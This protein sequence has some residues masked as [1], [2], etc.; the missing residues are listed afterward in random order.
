MGS[1]PGSGKGVRRGR[2]R[3]RGLGHT[4]LG[5]SGCRPQGQEARGTEQAIPT[6]RRGTRGDLFCGAPPNLPLNNVLRRPP[7][8]HA[9]A[10]QPQTG[11]S[12][13]AL[14]PRLAAVT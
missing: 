2:A 3:T 4:T 14:G 11:T 7:R 13:G 10:A 8:V 9:P 6:G 12:R 1:R 5:H